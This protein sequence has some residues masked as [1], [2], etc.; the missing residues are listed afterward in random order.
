MPG[1]KKVNTA[2]SEGGVSVGGLGWWAVRM[3]N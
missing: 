3:H 2:G 1:R